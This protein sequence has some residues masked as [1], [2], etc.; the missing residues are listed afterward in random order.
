MKQREGQDPPLH[1]YYFY[2]RRFSRVAEFKEVRR[3]LVKP[4]SEVSTKDLGRSSQ[5]TTSPSR[6]ALSRNSRVRL[7]VEV[8]SRSKI[9]IMDLSRT[10]ISL[11]ID[12]YMFTS[13]P[14]VGEGLDPPLFRF[15][16]TYNRNNPLPI[17]RDCF[18]YMSIFSHSLSDHG[19]H[20]HDK[21]SARF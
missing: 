20:D 6:S 2:F 3:T 12:K 1:F 5:G 9:P 18:L 21:T 7:E 14:F 11:P 16:Q 10:A 4:Y 19:S 15:P 17:L 8:L 13:N